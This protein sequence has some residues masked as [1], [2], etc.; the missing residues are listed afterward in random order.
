MRWIGEY[1]GLYKVS[2]QGNVYSYHNTPTGFKLKQSLS[3][4]GYPVVFLSK[5]NKQKTKP[6]HRAVAEAYIPPGN[7]R[8][9]VKHIDGVK[10]NNHVLNLEWCTPSENLEHSWSMGL[11]TPVTQNLP[12][13]K[14]CK[15]PSSKLTKLNVLKIRHLYKFTKV[16]YV[17]LGNQFG[18]S[19]RAI[20]KIINNLSYK[21]KEYE[22]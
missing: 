13:L 18:V 16:S 2:M 20:A 11:R 4:K 7:G 8:V 6:I 14:G 21:E 9:Q 12:L 5:N 15:S 19:K 1:E 22:I 17:K 3:K 10:T